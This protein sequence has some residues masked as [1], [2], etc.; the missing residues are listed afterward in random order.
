MSLH[1]VFVVT[2]VFCV[3]VAVTAVVAIVI[4]V[5]LLYFPLLLTQLL[6][7][8][9]RRSRLIV[10]IDRYV[11]LLHFLCRLASFSCWRHVRIVVVVTAIVEPIL[12]YSFLF[13][14][15][16]FS[17]H[18]PRLVDCCFVRSFARFAPFFHSFRLLPPPTA[19]FVSFHYFLSLHCLLACFLPPSL[20]CNTI[21]W[22]HCYTAT[23]IALLHGYIDCGTPPGRV[24]VASGTG[25]GEKF[26]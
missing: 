19:C 20:Q 13:L 12:T 2:H 8:R 15:L 11:V 23:L 1:E 26:R 18:F 3:V 9:R 5:Y 21:H 14:S 22:L 6:L 7:N 4:A 16:S 25:A 17:M 10:S 24:R